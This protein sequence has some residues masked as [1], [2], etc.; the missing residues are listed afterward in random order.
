FTFI[1][2]DI[3]LSTNSSQYRTIMDI[4]NNLLLYVEPKKEGANNKLRK[5]RLKI[6]LANNLPVLQKNIRHLLERVRSTLAELRRL[7]RE[8]YYFSRTNNN[9]LA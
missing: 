6:Q 5:L 3:Q 9:N 4:V 7:E 2:N 1:H 8:I